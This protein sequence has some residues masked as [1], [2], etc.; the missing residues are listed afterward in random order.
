L[1]FGD[2]IN[3]PRDTTTDQPET[4]SIPLQQSITPLEISSKLIE[5][6]KSITVELNRSKSHTITELVAH[7]ELPLIHPKNSPHFKVRYCDY[8]AIYCIKALTIY[9]Q[10]NVIE[11]LKPDV[12]LSK[13]KASFGSDVAGWSQ[14]ANEHLGGFTTRDVHGKLVFGKNQTKKNKMDPIQCQLRLPFC[15]FDSAFRFVLTLNTPLKIEISFQPLKLFTYRT[16]HYDT[17]PKWNC[18]LD[19]TYRYVIPNDEETAF[20]NLSYATPNNKGYAVSTIVTDVF[21]R[22]LATPDLKSI[23]IRK[24]PTQQLSL[25]LRDSLFNEDNCFMGDTI[26][27]CSINCIASCVKPI[28]SECSEYAFNFKTGLFKNGLNTLYPWTI[29]P[30]GPKCYKAHYNRDTSTDFITYIWSNVDFSE[31]CDGIFFDLHTFGEHTL[32]TVPQIYYF[33]TITLKF[34]TYN[35]QMTVDNTISEGDTVGLVEG[36]WVK[37]I[38]NKDLKKTCFITVD[39]IKPNLKVIDMRA[40]NQFLSTHFERVHDWTRVLPSK[41]VERHFIRMCDPLFNW[42]DFS[43]DTIYEMESVSFERQ[44]NDSITYNSLWLK[45]MRPK[46]ASLDM[47]RTSVDIEFGYKKTLGFIDIGKKEITNVKYV[48]EPLKM[49]IPG[50]GIT[51]PLDKYKQTITSTGSHSFDLIQLQKYSRTLMY[52][53]GE[54]NWATPTELVQISN[55]VYEELLIPEDYTKRIQKQFTE[56][57]IPQVSEKNNTSNRGNFISNKMENNFQQEADTLQFL[58]K[59]R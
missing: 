35:E 32:T 41:F 28:A 52:K 50:L 16:K 20:N 39:N 2:S 14:Y 54:L 46:T 18:E 58:N 31:L 56:T 1:V 8:P 10:N 34:D 27:S 53:G 13:L 4:F 25:I 55:I 19:I 23:F 33:S 9:A 42:T 21:D 43:R 59:K 22:S 30:F 17:L 44:G 49:E 45:L 3:S 38:N 6:E 48:L 37:N 11:V 57:F 40:Y 51:W 5:A 15:V 12:I 29:E 26:E 36:F 7:F 24:F 47:Y